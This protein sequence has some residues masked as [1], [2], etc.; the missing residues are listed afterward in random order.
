M[1]S[2][3][4]LRVRQAVVV[5]LLAGGCDD[6]GRPIVGPGRESLMPGVWMLHN[7]HWDR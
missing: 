2:G 4:A 3:I 5:M 1:N 6:G 7:G